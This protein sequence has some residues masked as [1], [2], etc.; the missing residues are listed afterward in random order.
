MLHDKGKECL[1]KRSLNKWLVK[2]GLIG[3]SIFLRRN[4]KA[5]RTVL[6]FH[7]NHCKSSIANGLVV[8][9]GLLA[10]NH[11]DPTA[12]EY[13]SQWHGVLAPQWLYDV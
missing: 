7:I 13:R 11:V 12:L 6:G 1:I 9:I 3:T 5:Q 8:D 4:D 10:Y 2:S